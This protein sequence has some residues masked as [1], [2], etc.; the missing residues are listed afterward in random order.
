MPR[1]QPL[2]APTLGA[3]AGF[4]K[5]RASVGA[6]LGYKAGRKGPVMGAE[7]DG[8]VELDGEWW[9]E[10]RVEGDGEGEGGAWVPRPGELWQAYD[11]AAPHGHHHR[12]R[13]HDRQQQR[14]QGEDEGAGPSHRPAH[15]VGA[16]RQAQQQGDW[17][18]RRPAGD[19]PHHQQQPQPRVP[20]ESAHPVLR[21]HRP[22]DAVLDVVRALGERMGVPQEVLER[23]AQRYRG[24]AAALPGFPDEPTLWRGA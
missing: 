7:W 10:S 3:V 15:A 12:G 18:G 22:Q 9:L 17:E 20:I 2:P 21:P 11:A 8:E 14:Q 6:F 5:A 4:A 24:L 16:R 19:H 23:A 1:K 13:H